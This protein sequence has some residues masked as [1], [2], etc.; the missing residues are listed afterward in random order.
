MTKITTIDNLYGCRFLSM[1]VE[2]RDG[3]L[4]I[5]LLC[6]IWV[7]KR[8]ENIACYSTEFSID[9]ILKDGQLRQKIR[10]MWGSDFVPQITLAPA[11]ME[12]TV[13]ET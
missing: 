7:N 12:I 5:H 3:S 1:E 10:A 13:T 8:H 9:D 6:P 11:P 4:F 2:E